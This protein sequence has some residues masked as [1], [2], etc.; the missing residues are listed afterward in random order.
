[1]M[2]VMKD[3]EDQVEDEKYQ[4]ECSLLE[5]GCSQTYFEY[6]ATSSSAL[7][8]HLIVQGLIKGWG[9][10]IWVQSSWMNTHVRLG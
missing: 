8:D 1:M 2:S 5:T 7:Q 9:G 10:G 3:G 4:W 6:I